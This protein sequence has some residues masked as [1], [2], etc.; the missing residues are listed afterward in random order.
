MPITLISPNKEKK[1]LDFV[2]SNGL[3]LVMKHDDYMVSNQRLMLGRWSLLLMRQIRIMR[4]MLN[5]PV[6]SYGF[7]KETHTQARHFSLYM[8]DNNFKLFCS[9]NPPKVLAFYLK[10]CVCVD[11]KWYW[12]VY[13]FEFIL[14]TVIIIKL[15][16]N[17]DPHIKNKIIYIQIDGFLKNL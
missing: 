16:Q 1:I 13:M 6:F 2:Q 8:E 10:I 9:T 11:L 4:C 17:L 5:M 12:K 3:W 14:D 7:N 15:Y